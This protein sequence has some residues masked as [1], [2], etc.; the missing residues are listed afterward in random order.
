MRAGAAVALPVLARRTAA[1]SLTGLEWAVGVP[2]SVGGAVRMNAGG[3]GSDVSRTLAAARIVD[4]DRDGAR[5]VVPAQL[6]FAYRRSSVRAGQVVVRAD[7]ALQPGDRAV[8][9]A[10]IAEIVRWRRANQPGGA[11]GGSVFTN[12]A[13]SRTEAYVTG[14]FG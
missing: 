7:F 5:E 12:P 13:D 9:E 3:H 2:G 8:S 4:L 10:E 14:R 6:D 1:L 11:N